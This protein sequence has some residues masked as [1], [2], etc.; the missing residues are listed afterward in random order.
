MDLLKARR[1]AL[2]ADHE[3]AR[4]RAAPDKIIGQMRF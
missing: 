1:R 3:L 4:L 2:A